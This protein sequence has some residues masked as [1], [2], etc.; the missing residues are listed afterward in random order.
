MKLLKSK[1]N[2][3]EEI[4]HLINLANHEILIF[5]PYIKVNTLETLLLDSQRSAK[6]TIVTSWKPSDILLG[7]SDI[8][9]YK[10]CCDHK[11]TLLINNKIHLKAIIIDSMTSAYIGSG[12]ITNAGLGIGKRFNYELGVINEKIAIDDK[13]Y[14]DK[15]ISEGF[16]VN[17]EYYKKVKQAVAAMKKPKIEQE[18]DI[19]TDLQK[20][21][22]LNALPMSNNVSDFYQHYSRK[23]NDDGTEEDIRSAEHDIRLY[24]IPRGLNKT[25]F[26]KT[27][28]KSFLNHPFVLAYLNYV[29]EGKFFGEMSSWL[30][31]TV[32]TV[33][34]PRRYDIKN[35]QSRLNEFVVFLNDKYELVTPGRRSTRLQRIQ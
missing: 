20:D 10:Y 3:N 21:F 34:T 33:P 29:D 9:V 16:S 31:S 4:K 7:V 26:K 30:H 11:A 15:I 25:E 23:D 8:E 12:N 27:L 13:F 22:L 17:D 24:Q 14:F 1:I 18:F 6:V 5:S 32:T 19:E 28:T 35:A 2:F